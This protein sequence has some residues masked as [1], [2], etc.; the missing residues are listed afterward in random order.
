MESGSLLRK[1]GT[2]SHPSE[3][4]LKRSNRN[5][6]I[7]NEELVCIC[8]VATV[9]SSHQP[10][11]LLLSLLVMSLLPLLASDENGH[12]TPEASFRLRVVVG[13]EAGTVTFRADHYSRMLVE[14]SVVS[15]RINGEV[16]KDTTVELSFTLLSLSTSCL[17]FSVNYGQKKKIFNG[18]FDIDT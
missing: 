10:A 4:T 13:P 12:P 2:I 11:A 6:M 5:V 17:G 3:P 18:L 14:W 9:A 8:S 16:G 1:E 7:R 15:E